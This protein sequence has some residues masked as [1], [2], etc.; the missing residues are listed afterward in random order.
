MKLLTEPV[1]RLILLGAPRL[2][3]VMASA[4]SSIWDDCGYVPRQL[5]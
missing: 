4:E 2:H 3:W 5:I 1:L